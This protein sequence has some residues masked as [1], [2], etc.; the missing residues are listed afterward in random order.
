MNLLSSRR[1]TEAI[2]LLSL[3]MAV[4]VVVIIAIASMDDS[5]TPDSSFIGDI[6]DV[7]MVLVFA[8]VGVTIALKRPGNLVGWA[9]ILAGTGSMFG[10]VMNAYAELA[11]RAK[12]EEHLPGGTVAAAINGGS[13]TPLICG[14]F[15]LILL[16]PSG[17]IP[18]RR[19]RP[20]AKLLPLGM[21]IVWLAITTTPGYFDPP[22]DAYRNPL[23]FTDNKSY[24]VVIFPVIAFCLVSTVIAAIDLIVRFWHSRGD[25]REQYKWLAAS[26]G[27]LVATLP[28][29]AIF[30]YSGVAGAAFSVGLIS[31]PI[32]VGVAVLRYNL[33]GIDRIINRTLVYGFVTALLAVTYFGLVVGLQPVLDAVNGGSGLAVAL[34]TLIVAALFFPLRQRVQGVVDRRFNRRAYDGARTIEAFSARLRQ[35]VDL[36]SL[37]YELLSVVDETM[38]PAGV[39][40]WLR[41]PRSVR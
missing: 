11:L 40:L 36:D 21:A 9:M 6:T 3:V 31:L 23:A 19:W 10:D 37:R 8:I 15:L 12:P 35:E 34:T 33:Y 39:S 18:S 22:F 7:V 30:N 25:E 29:G 38:E 5:Y 24:I 20:V 2:A 17:Q 26:A 14:V 13:W 4:F 32:S 27:L 41:Q 1:L 28:F 16:F